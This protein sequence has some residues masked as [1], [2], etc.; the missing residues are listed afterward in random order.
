MAQRRRNRGRNAAAGPAGSGPPTVL[1]SVETRGPADGSL[2]GRRRV[3]LLNSTYEPLTALP[4]RRAWLPA[5]RSPG[6]RC[7][8]CPR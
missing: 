8:T 3:L 7:S 2:W 6:S 5:R 1:R 4:I